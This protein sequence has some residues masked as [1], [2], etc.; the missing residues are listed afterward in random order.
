M[1]AIDFF[2]G[3]ITD[4]APS[5]T[6]LIRVAVPTI[7][8]QRNAI[9]GPMPFRPKWGRGL[10]VSLP[11]RG[12]KA[13]IAIDKDG[14]EPWVVDWMP[15]DNGAAVAGAPGPKGDKGDQGLPGAQGAQ[16]IPGATGAQG[17]PGT[18]GA[19]GP[20]GVKGDP[21]PPSYDTDHIGTVKTWT[22]RTIPD[23]YLL[24]DG[25]TVNEVDYPD[26]AAWVAPEVAAGNTT[27]GITGVAPNRVITVP[28]LTRR[29]VYGKNASDV[30]GTKAGEATHALTEAEMP[31]HTHGAPRINPAAFYG[32][33]APGSAYAFGDALTG[34]TGGNQAHNNLPPYILLALIVK[35]RGVTISGDA[36]Q[37]PTGPQGPPGDMA[38]P[39]PLDIWHVVGDATTGLGTTFQNGWANLYAAVPV[40]FKKDV[41]GN[42][43]VRGSVQSG[44]I[45]ATVFTLPVGYRPIGNYQSFH[46]GGQSGATNP[47][48]YQYVTGAGQ[49]IVGAPATNVFISLDSIRFE[50]AGAPTTFP[51]G[52]KGPT[53]DPGAPGAQGPPGD[54]PASYVLDQWH[55]VGAVGEPAFGTGVTN[56]AGDTPAAFR[57]YPDGK[58]RL[59]G[60]VNHP[61]VAASN[62]AVLFT[63]PSGYGAATGQ[64]VRFVNVGTS[65]AYMLRV[66]GTEVQLWNTV[67]MTGPGAAGQVD[68]GVVEFDTDTV[69]TML[70][71]PKGDTGPQ[72]PAGD[73][74]ASYVIDPWHQVTAFSNGYG[75]YGAGYG[76]VS[77]R[78]MPDGTVRLKGLMIV[79]TLN[80]TGFTLPVGYRPSRASTCIVQAGRDTYTLVRLNINS[81]GTV[82]SSHAAAWVSLDSIS[83]IAEDVP[84][85]TMLAGP[86]GDQGVPGPEGGD[87]LHP[88]GAFYAYRSAAISQANATELVLD[89]ERYDVEN[90][91]NT[92]TGRYT[93]QQEGYYQFD[94]CYTGGTALAAGGYLECY[95]LKNGQLTQGSRGTRSSDLGSN[96]PVVS[97]STAFYMNGT[98]DYVTIYLQSSTTPIAVGTGAHQTF[99][100]GYRIGA[101]AVGPVGP[102]GPPWMPEDYTMDV[103]HNVGAAGEPV[104]TNSWVNYDTGTGA[105]GT[106]QQRNA[107]FRKYPDGKVR[108]RGVIRNGANGTM[109]FQLPVGY[110]PKTNGTQSFACNA[111]TD[112]A[113]VGVDIN[114]AVMP[115]NVGGAVVTSWCYLDGV[116]F[117]TEETQML[118]GPRGATGPSGA[119]SYNLPT[120]RCS[121]T[122][123]IGIG[124][125]PV[126]PFDGV[127]PNV[128][129]L[130]L[131]WAQATL[132]ENGLY[133]YNG[134]G[135]P[136]TRHED[137]AL[138]QTLEAGVRV[139]VAEGTLFGQRDFYLRTRTL[140]GYDNLIFSPPRGATIDDQ[141]LRAGADNAGSNTITAGVNTNA[142]IDAANTVLMRLLFT[143]PVDCWWELDAWLYYNK[144]DAAY[145]YANPAIYVTPIP[146]ESTSTGSADPI[147][148][149]YHSGVV[150]YATVNI[151][152][153]FKLVAGVA[154]TAQ[155]R[156][157]C[158]TAGFVF[159]KGDRYSGMKSQARV[160]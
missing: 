139:Y 113:S 72:G 31:S 12:E 36:L 62:K 149:G 17:V 105:P 6:G 80:A 58:V 11:L 147:M 22:G 76:P 108:L 29:F 44:T 70:A 16:G 100:T 78:R 25:R 37:G 54:S 69:T 93:P 132:R 53:G 151:Q 143:P 98:T 26:L 127:T 141:R 133:R 121:T 136:M 119:S 63:L 118:A 7:N 56:G 41:F 88:P 99:L 112:D 10:G 9:Y 24:A 83:F 33:S 19:A 57:K 65:G 101:G 86:K 135:V 13:L 85:T 126:P 50:A 14:G 116:E 51:V 35:A 134:L 95:L 5:A 3:E 48:S 91:F 125:A 79:G 122:V 138:G 106:I 137:A 111:N 156:H 68:L 148:S 27:W 140:I 28:D 21:G 43:I 49:V 142:W 146:L 55:A 92:T 73:A 128:G 30:L 4:D 120:A 20:Q 34:P 152:D 109:A 157:Y 154:Y 115:S 66:E 71:G 94:W 102:E 160:R 129:D 38:D 8:T 87:P 74:P 117:D 89:A 32:I 90:W 155:V 15:T 123:N 144:S 110:R 84:V 81:D 124:A 96:G 45:G 18:T 2:N 130:V 158:S 131:V 159:Q 40:A 97:G 104:F 75:D 82:N 42:V 23:E 1:S 145:G 61:A 107:Q 77:Y 60:W 46:G 52:P 39:T 114:G 64:K 67:G 59:R 47:G 103:W 150:Q 153:K